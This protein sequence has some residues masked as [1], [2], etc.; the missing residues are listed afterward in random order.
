MLAQS[1]KYF[2]KAEG[3]SNSYQ[4]FE[5]DRGLFIMEVNG[6]RIPDYYVFLE[7]ESMLRVYTGAGI[8]LAQTIPYHEILFQ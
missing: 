2:I 1:T 3:H 7:P 5:I 4:L 6:V 8:A